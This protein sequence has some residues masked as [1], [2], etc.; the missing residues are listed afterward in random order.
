[1]KKVH[2]SRAFGPIVIVALIGSPMLPPETAKARPTGAA[3]EA[4]SCE[5]AIETAP[6][7]GRPA[8][9]AGRAECPN[10]RFEGMLTRLE[11][12]ARG[13]DGEA[14]YM[15]GNIFMHGIH[16]PVDERAGDRYWRRAA[17]LGHAPAQHDYAISLLRGTGDVSSVRPGA[18]AETLEALGWLEKAAASGH[19]ISALVLGRLYETGFFGIRIDLCRAIGWY[20]AGEG[21]GAPAP[22]GHLDAIRARLGPDCR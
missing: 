9:P 3:P 12:Q 6:L 4:Q 13:G 20:E 15:L 7:L 16:V 2:N 10:V 1:M 8:C 21:L 14:A 11:C 18:S 19:V 17:H 22:H 5:A